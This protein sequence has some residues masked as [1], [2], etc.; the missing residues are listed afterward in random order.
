M[1]TLS[2]L[3]QMLVL[4]LHSCARCNWLWRRLSPAV[5][6]DRGPLVLLQLSVCH[7]RAP[8]APAAASCTSSSPTPPSLRRARRCWSRATRWTSPQPA[9]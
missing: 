4:G 3:R 1:H 7:N 2:P 5:H 8:L 9:V 6:H